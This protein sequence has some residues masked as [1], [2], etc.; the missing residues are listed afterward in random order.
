VRIQIDRK[1]NFYLGRNFYADRPL[2]IWFGFGWR[3]DAGEGE[4]PWRHFWSWSPSPWKILWRDGR[5]AGFCAF[6]RCRVWR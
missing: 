2:L 1:F 3:E 4:I 6:G 5:I